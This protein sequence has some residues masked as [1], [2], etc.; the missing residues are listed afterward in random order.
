MSELPEMYRDN[1]QNSHPDNKLTIITHFI[2]VS[3]SN[4]N[5]ALNYVFFFFKIIYLNHTSH[6]PPYFMIVNMI[7]RLFFKFPH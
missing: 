4:L 5:F 2:A 1:K 7:D 6:N 3:N